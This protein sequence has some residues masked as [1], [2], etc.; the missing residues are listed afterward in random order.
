M[1][2]LNVQEKLTNQN[3][4]SYNIYKCL[5]TNKK[6]LKTKFYQLRYNLWAKFFTKHICKWVLLQWNSKKKNHYEQNSSTDMFPSFS[7]KVVEIVIS[8]VITFE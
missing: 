3:Y 7:H 1:F 2:L 6:L 5:K 4:H 8:N